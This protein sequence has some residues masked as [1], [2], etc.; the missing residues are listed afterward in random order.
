MR[1]VVPWALV[2]SAC[3]TPPPT[4]VTPDLP[5]PRALNGRTLGQ[6]D[7]TTP[8]PFL[9]AGHIYGDMTRGQY[10][11]ETFRRALP[12]LAQLGELMFLCGD[13]FRLAADPWLTET[14]ATLAE[15][16]FPVFNAPGNHD[17]TDR[18]AYERR[19]GP[20]FGAFVHGGCLFVQLDTERDVWQI[21][22]EQLALLRAAL[23]EAER[24]PDI[25]A[26]FC[27]AHRLVF[28]HRQR[29]L[30][31]LLSGNAVDG[32]SE[33]NRFAADVLPHL[34]A[35]AAKKPVHWWAGDV[36]TPGSLPFFFD[37]DPLSGVCFGA[38]GL[39][40]LPRDVVARIEVQ[41]GAA[42]PASV[43]VT[44]AAI[45]GGAT[46]PVEAF[47]VE[48]WRRHRFPEGVPPDVEAYR[49]QLPR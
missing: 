4:P 46:E 33:P 26:V 31:V 7:A 29:Y 49:T 30:E 18:A 9:V 22:G 39:G 32:L 38:I 14:A 42:G 5:V 11:A 35:V 23:A 47:G 19:H 8:L 44:L 43:T 2:L 20:T 48:R 25:R 16:P 37:R 21:S 1:R 15:L 12:Q 40:D 27:F 41:G 6:R 34:Q 36:G 28:A 10:P 24:R 17:L 13:T 3:G 45:G